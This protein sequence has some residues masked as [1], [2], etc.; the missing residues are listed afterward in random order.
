MSSVDLIQAAR[1]KDSAKGGR[2]IANALADRLEAALANVCRWNC[3]QDLNVLQGG[4]HDWS[5]EDSVTPRGFWAAAFKDTYGQS[6]SVQESSVMPRLWVGVDCC[7]MH[8]S[9]AQARG[10]ADLLGR[11]AD[12]VGEEVEE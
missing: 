3:A 9:P 11:W 5:P 2:T 1:E 4:T 7:R 6:C 8:I 10:I 12:E